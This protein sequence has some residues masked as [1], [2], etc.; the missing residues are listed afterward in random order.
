MRDRLGM[1]P[2]EVLAADPGF[3]QRSLEKLIRPRVLLVLHKEH[4]SCYDFPGALK[5]QPW[6][7]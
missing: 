3:L 2:R 6:S 5:L 1:S 7:H 4:S